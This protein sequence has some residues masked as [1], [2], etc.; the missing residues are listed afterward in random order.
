ME[1]KYTFWLVLFKSTAVQNKDTNE[2]S[3]FFVVPATW[4]G[5]VEVIRTC[6]SKA[7]ED[8]MQHLDELKL[9][10]V[11]EFEK[12]AGF[13]FLAAKK[14][15]DGQDPNAPPFYSYQYFCSLP[16]PRT[17]WQVRLFL[18]CEMR[19]LKLFNGDGYTRT[20]GGVLGSLEYLC[21]NVSLSNFDPNKS[22]IIPMVVKIPE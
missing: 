15:E 4:D 17:S 10:T 9:K 6:Y 21:P 20:E 12:I 18:Y 2:R 1:K 7:Y 13:E 5:I 14:N 11:E 8:V 3:D 19:L 22:A 16:R